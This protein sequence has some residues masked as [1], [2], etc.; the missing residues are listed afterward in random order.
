MIVIVNKSRV[1]IVI[2]LL[3]MIIGSPFVIK[4]MLTKEVKI[5]KIRQEQLNTE[6]NNKIKNSK[7]NKPKNKSKKEQIENKP[8]TIESLLIGDSRTVGISEYGGM[9]NATFFADTGMSVYNVLEK[10]L[11]IDNDKVNLEKLLTIKKFQKIYIML[12]INELGYDM[13]VTLKKYKE[14]IDFIKEKQNSAIIYIEA[15]LHVAEE[16]NKKDETFNNKRINI[17]NNG[18]KKIANNKNI[19]YLDVNEIFDDENG[20]LRSDYTHDNVHIYAK[21]YKEWAKWLEK[22]EM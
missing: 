4:N 11:K 14:V 3:S 20:N 8:I 2:F 9:K 13:E 10:E 1:F 12:G 15:N 5:S 16:Q 19:F 7:E 18:I 22:G 21:Y 6:I 17:F